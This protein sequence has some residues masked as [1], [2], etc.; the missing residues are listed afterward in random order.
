V[1]AAS[2]GLGPGLRY[3]YWE[4]I[5]PRLGLA[6]MP[7]SSHDT[8]VRASAG[9]YSVPVL[10]AVLYSLLGIDTSYYGTYTP[11]TSTPILNF[12][13]VFSGTPGVSSFPGYRR[14]NQWNLKDPRVYQWNASFDRNIGYQTLLRVSYVGSHTV[15]LIYS[16]NLNQVAPNTASYTDPVTGKTVY[17]YAALTATTALRDQNLKFPNFAEVLTRNNAPSDKYEAL[18]IELSRRFTQ[19]LSFSN[20]YTLGS[21]RTNALGTAP[22]SAIPTGGQGDNGGNVNNIYDIKSDTGNAYYDPR[23]SFISTVVY[24]LPFGRGKKY[25]ANS[26]RAADL[27]IGG[28]SVTGIAMLHSGFWETPYYPASAYDSSGTYP[29]Q[30]SVKQQRP[31]CSGTSGYLSN[32]TT[33][34]FF[35]VSAYNV[36]THPV[37]AAGTPEPIGRFGNCGVGILEGPGTVTFSMST[38]K[39]FRITERFGLRYEAQFS[40]LFNLVNWGEP[41][42]NITGKFGLISNAQDVS[43]AGPRTIQMS[44]RFQF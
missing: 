1:S 6:W 14:A 19:G 8:V 22:N 29:T 12:T 30:R 25:S 10:G 26:S 4:N 5:Q 28:W 42:M 38:G 17:G 15:D 40:N 11:T 44:L 20:S 37:D 39:T 35:N 16:P 13:N 34:A 31:D 24:D 23:N 33:A 18:T 27:A 36:P 32:P 43:Q 21:N 2:V 3:T 41:S 9:T 7:S